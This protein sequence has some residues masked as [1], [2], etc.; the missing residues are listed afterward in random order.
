MPAFTPSTLGLVAGRRRTGQVREQAD[1]E[2][3]LPRW[4]VAPDWPLLLVD[5]DE[6][7]PTAPTTTT[8]AAASAPMRPLSY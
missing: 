8:V 6:L 2:G 4:T 5:P 3:L 1:R 7:Q